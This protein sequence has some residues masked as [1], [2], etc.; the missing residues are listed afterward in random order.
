MINF[1]PHYEIIGQDVARSAGGVAILSNPEEVQFED[2]ISIPRILSRIFRI[3]GSQEWILLSN[4]YGTHTQSD[5]RL[6]LQNFTVMRSLY[7]TSPWIVGGDFNM[8]KSIN[9]KNGGLRRIEADMKTF[10]DWIAEQRLVEIQTT[11]G[12][13]A[14]NNRRGGRHKFASRLD[15]FLMSEQ[16]I[17]WDIF[18]EAVI[19]PGM[20]LENWPIN[21]ELDIREIPKRKP[22]RF[23]AFQLKDKNFMKKV[24]EWWKKSRQE[25]K[26]QNAYIPAEAKRN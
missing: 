22:F 13:Y 12:I 2:K 26:K 6:F 15:Q 21:A 14:W 8:I 7:P 17:N 1:K 24:E 20:G 25:R 19:L 10:G 4:V 9:K 11:N 23:E 3:L 16:I 18:F 5:Q